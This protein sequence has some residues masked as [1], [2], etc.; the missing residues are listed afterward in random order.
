[1]KCPAITD[2]ALRPGGLLGVTH[3][4]G[5][6]A[7]CA[8]MLASATALA[9]D[10]PLGPVADPAA[11]DRIV[12]EVIEAGGLPFLYVRLENGD[13]RVLYEHSAR[14]PALMPFAVDGDSWIR[15]W[16]MSKIVTATVA[17]DLVEEGVIGMDDP[18]TKTIPEFAALKVAV[19]PRGEDLVTTAPEERAELCPLGEAPLERPITVRHLIN[20]QDGLTYPWTGVPCIDEPFRDALLTTS[21]DSDGLIRKLAALPLVN[22]PG[23]EENYGM[24]TT[25][26]G[27]VLERATGQSLAELV[28]ERITMPLGIDRLRYGLPEGELLPP[29]FS[30]DGGT[31]KLAEPGELDIFGEAVPFY[32]PDLPL[33]LGGEGMIGSAAA[34][35]RFLRMILHRGELD[36]Y[37]VLDE[38]TVEEMVQPHT[39]TDN[40]W[41]HAG[42]TIW[43]SNGRRSSGDVGPAPLWV[44]GGYEGTSYWIDPVNDLVGVIM[45]Q[46]HD[47]PP[48][49]DNVSEAI[50]TALYEQLGW[51]RA[52]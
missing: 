21:G 46:I 42:Y 18:I 6:V 27:L 33:Y 41:G 47:A 5:V 49:A 50:G 44:G 45:T 36:G 13:G 23:T 17:L 7:L 14:N 39:M 30:G 1:M 10:Q 20:H 15:I 24:G 3:S 19:G 51:S 40:E 28:R 31:L 2:R 8:G 4:L 29:R 48:A 11:V 12:D 35:A 32:D 43:V 34:Y 22:Q 26:L 16:S 9:G 52:D 38:A 37:R 25:V